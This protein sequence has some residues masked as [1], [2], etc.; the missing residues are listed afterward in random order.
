[1]M[2]IGDLMVEHRLIERVVGL[3]EKECARIDAAGRV[4][5]VFLDSAVDF[6]VFYADRCHHGKEEE[7]L[8]AEL[9]AHGISDA[10]KAMIEE[11]KEDHVAGRQLVAR[12]DAD[13]RL[14]CSRCDERV[15]KTINADIEALVKLYQGHIEK[16][17]K[18]FFIP[19]MQYL[20]QQEQDG[21]LRRF[22]EFDRLLIHEKYRKI[23]EGFEKTF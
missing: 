3:L 1:M 19:A 2:P 21:M 13:V 23:T 10:H 20:S 17:D 22:W 12:L 11:L 8:F 16:E 6:F 14:S 18:R 7:I 15:L 9:L 5:T 4:D